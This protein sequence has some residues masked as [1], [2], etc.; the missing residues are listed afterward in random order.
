MRQRHVS[1]HDENEQNAGEQA[2]QR[3]ENLA[4]AHARARASVGGDSLRWQR[5]RMADDERREGIGGG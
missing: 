3:A 4:L 1:R 5:R 2:A